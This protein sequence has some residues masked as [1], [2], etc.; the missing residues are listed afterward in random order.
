MLDTKEILIRVLITSEKGYD[1]KVTPK[2]DLLKPQ[3]ME[4]DNLN[5]FLPIMRKGIYVIQNTSVEYAQY[6]H[7]S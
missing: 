3:V 7:V 1:S 5:G 6:R 4:L 2:D